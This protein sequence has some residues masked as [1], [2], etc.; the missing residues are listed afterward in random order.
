MN[1][2]STLGLGHETNQRLALLKRAH[3]NDM[4]PCRMFS[5]SISSRT[6]CTPASRSA[7]AAMLAAI[8]SWISTSLSTSIAHACG[9]IVALH[10]RRMHLLMPHCQHLVL[11]RRHRLLR[12]CRHCQCRRSCHGQRSLRWLI[13]C[14]A[15]FRPFLVLRVFT[16][17]LR[18]TGTF[19]LGWP[20]RLQ[21]LWLFLHM[22]LL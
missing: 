18:G 1:S 17:A 15:H 5:I 4:S 11:Q 13:I 8:C 14:I 16:L 9:R 2:C 10:R 19:L 6:S 7:N 12:H 20:R 21:R 3:V 22:V